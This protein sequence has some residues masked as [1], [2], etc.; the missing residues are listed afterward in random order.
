MPLAISAKVSRSQADYYIG[1]VE[2]RIFHIFPQA[3][4]ST[5]AGS[6]DAA[7]SETRRADT[8]AARAESSLVRG[9]TETPYSGLEWLLR[10]L[11]GPLPPF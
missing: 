1:A 3:G 7:V 8:Q 6:N 10:S 11:L 2:T 4:R 9:A 5:R